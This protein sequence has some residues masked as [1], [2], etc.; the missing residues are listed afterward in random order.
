MTGASSALHEAV[1]ATR[2][3]AADAVSTF[4]RVLGLTLL[5]VGLIVLIGLRRVL[6][7]APGLGAEPATP[8]AH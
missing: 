3:E 7:R 4:T 2:D 5:V 1:N 6:Q 8:P